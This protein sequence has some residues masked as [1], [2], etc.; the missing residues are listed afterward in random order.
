MAP[1]V[2]RIRRTWR[3]MVGP[4]GWAG[5]PGGPDI[6]AV[7]LVGSY[8]RGAPTATS[9]VDL[10][11]L[12]DHPESYLRDRRWPQLFGVVVAD[13]IEDYGGVT[14]LRVWYED[15]LEVEY[16][17]TDRTWADMPL[18]AGTRRVISGGMRVL[19]ER[20]PLLSRHLLRP[21]ARPAN[22]RLQRTRRVLR[23][24]RGILPAP[25]SP[26]PLDARWTP[27]YARR[28]V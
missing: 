22:R 26:S 3:H 13:R 25:L 8:A 28:R 10:V 14:S 24:V 17:L 19:F 5:R 16:G 12:V 11:L 27:P 1:G 7:A 15:R 2:R 20:E 18:D 23:T 6:E 4:S 21:Q 9:D